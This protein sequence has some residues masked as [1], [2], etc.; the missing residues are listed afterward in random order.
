MIVNGNSLIA[1]KPI[2]NMFTEKR[3][4]NITSYGL[5]EAGYDIRIKQNII[6]EPS[7]NSIFI[8]GKYHGSGTF[9]LASSIEKFTMPNCL[10][11]T[12]KDKSTWAR[13]GLAV[14]NTVIESLWHG[15]LT[16]ELS[17]M[18]QERLE[19]PAG[20]G[21]AQVLFM[22]LENMAEYRGKYQNQAD[23]PVEAIDSKDSDRL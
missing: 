15:H 1:L 19:I 17:Y 8:D 2:E 14:Q 5:S 18:G 11:G 7:T 6:F 10:V 13:R 4:G 22:R 21:I 20:E 16:L 12:V 23:R 9:V 3:K